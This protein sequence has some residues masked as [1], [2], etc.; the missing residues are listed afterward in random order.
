MPIIATTIEIIIT[1]SGTTTIERNDKVAINTTTNAV[2]MPTVFLVNIAAKIKGINDN[3]S[4]PWKLRY[5]WKNET[6]EA[7]DKEEPR[8]AEY[9]WLPPTLTD[10]SAGFATPETLKY[11]VSSVPFVVNDCTIALAPVELKTITV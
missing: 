3:M 6:V 1:C 10:N 7:K 4:N 9:T 8:Y 11:R 2:P 5:W